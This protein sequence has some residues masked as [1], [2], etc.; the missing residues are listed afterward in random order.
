MRSLDLAGGFE[1][2]SIVGIVKEQL[3]W[4][5]SKLHKEKDVAW[6]QDLAMALTAAELV[7]VLNLPHKILNKPAIVIKHNPSM[8][9]F[10]VT[11]KGS[12]TYQSRLSDFRWISSWF[13]GCF[14]AYIYRSKLGGLVLGSCVSG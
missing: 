11:I 9:D 2:D 1:G 12:S 4:A 10:T 5:L 6:A 7:D 13:L 3:E 8:W 14:T